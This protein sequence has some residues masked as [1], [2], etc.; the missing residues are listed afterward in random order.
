MAGVM[1]AAAGKGEM[2]S[3]PGFWNKLR[4]AFTILRADLAALPL[5]PRMWRKRRQVQHLAKLTPAEI[6]RLI[7]R[8]RIPLR[9]LIEKSG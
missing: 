8:H 5:L 2:A 9:A 1:A 3:F 6:R 7:L 4:L